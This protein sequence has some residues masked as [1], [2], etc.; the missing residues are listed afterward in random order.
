MGLTANTDLPDVYSEATETSRAEANRSPLQRQVLQALSVLSGPATSREL[1]AATELSTR[2]LARTLGGLV[3]DGILVEE[4][5]SGRTR[6][7]FNSRVVRGGFLETVSKSE[8]KRIHLSL[9]SYFRSRKKLSLE[10]SERL[11]LHLFR[12]GS[13][14]A[15]RQ[16]ARDTVVALRARGLLEGALRILKEVLLGERSRKWRLF[17]SEQVSAIH[18]EAGDHQEGVSALIQLNLDEL[19]PREAVRV[20]RRMGAHHHRAGFAKEAKEVF[21]E[22]IVLADPSKDG[23]E[24]VFVYSE[25]AELH[26]LRDEYEAAQEACRKGLEILESLKLDDEKFRG[27]MEMMLRGS[28]G[29]LELRRFNLARSRLE[30]ERAERL[31][32]R[33][34]SASSRVLLL[35]NLGVVFNHQNDLARA[36]RCYEKAE[37]LLRRSGKRRERILISTNLAT[38]AA[39]SGRAQEARRYLDTAN[40]LLAHSPD[41]RCLI[42]GVVVPAFGIFESSGIGPMDI[43]T[44]TQAGAGVRD[45]RRHLKSALAREHVEPSPH[46][47]ALVSHFDGSVNSAAKVHH[48]LLGRLAISRTCRIASTRSTGRRDFDRPPQLRRDAVRTAPRLLTYLIPDTGL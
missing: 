32:R 36:L 29:H 1:Q 8:K 39:K 11:A 47:E 31:S 33:F 10:D 12:G 23:R 2:V 20:R 41:R 13:R 17:F 44:H 28:M 43:D 46:V 9:V 14:V 24:L 26:T 5:V 18:Y 19:G 6:F 40:D 35:N 7:D 15:A 37:A 45:I 25:L 3:S 21:H 27:E 48:R 38:I 30:L 16:M 42:I 22:A 4:L 34:G